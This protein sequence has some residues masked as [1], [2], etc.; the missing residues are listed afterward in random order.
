MALVRGTSSVPFTRNGVV[1]LRVIVSGRCSGEHQVCAVDLSGKG[2][3]QRR[4][5]AY[6]MYG[7]FHL[8]FNQWLQRT[9]SVCLPKWGM[10][11]VTTNLGSHYSFKSEGAPCQNPLS[12]RIE[13]RFP[14]I[15]KGRLVSPLE[16]DLCQSIFYF[17]FTAP[18]AN[19]PTLLCTATEVNEP[20]TKS[21]P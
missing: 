20:V 3:A 2:G 5:A 15:K 6:R 7:W 13:L 16:N 4:H 12:I 18:T 8:L 9:L 17:C 11:G 10:D 1:R 21:W 19:P 14:S